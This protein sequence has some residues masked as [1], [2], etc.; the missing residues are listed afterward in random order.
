MT[1]CRSDGRVTEVPIGGRVGPRFEKSSSRLP[2]QLL[3]ARS[4]I[5]LTS[6]QLNRLTRLAKHS[7][8]LAAL[9]GVR[10]P[11]DRARPT[12]VCSS[13]TAFHVGFPPK[14]PMVILV[15]RGHMQSC[16]AAGPRSPFAIDSWRRTEYL[17]FL[18][19]LG[20]RHQA[21]D[22]VGVVVR[23]SSVVASARDRRAPLYRRRAPCLHRAR[24][25]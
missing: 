20:R 13:V 25:A 22:E 4:I 12:R 18:R 1:L 6:R 23:L 5:E 19:P 21:V 24:V 10:A 8:G 15:W 11:R 16:Y 17:G 7:F 14:C 2:C 3:T 9:T